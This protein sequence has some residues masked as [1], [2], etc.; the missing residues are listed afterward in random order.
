M[1]GTESIDTIV[2]ISEEHLYWADIINIF[3][4]GGSRG[5]STILRPNSVKLPV[6]SRAPKTHN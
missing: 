6:L 4:R 1:A 3:D 2:N 5:N